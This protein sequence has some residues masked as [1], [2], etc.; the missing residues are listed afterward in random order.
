MLRRPQDAFWPKWSTVPS[1]PYVGL[2]IRRFPVQVSE[3]TRLQCASFPSLHVKSAWRRKGG[4]KTCGKEV[5]VQITRIT[6][7]LRLGRVSAND[8][9]SCGMRSQRRPEKNS[10][11][12][13]LFPEPPLPA[14]DHY[15]L[16]F[17]F[18]SSKTKHSK[19]L[20]VFFQKS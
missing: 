16:F 19:K 18:P 20:A 4:D 11:F 2:P 8:A 1:P 17:L 9:K 7:S 13:L 6:K 12:Y 5:T 10:V 14:V 15:A 3:S